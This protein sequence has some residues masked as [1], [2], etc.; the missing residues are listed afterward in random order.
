MP[1]AEPTPVATAPLLT[2][3]LR[4]GSGCRTGGKVDRIGGKV[5]RIGGGGGV[6]A[7]VLAVTGGAFAEGGDAGG[8]CRGVSI[9]GGTLSPE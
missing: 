9:L 2:A 5:D 7:F 3:A 4:F 1:F 8:G 6:G